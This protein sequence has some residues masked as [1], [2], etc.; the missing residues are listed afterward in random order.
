MIALLKSRLED[1]YD[2]VLVANT[3]AYIYKNLRRVLVDV[4]NLIPFQTVVSELRREVESSPSDEYDQASY[5]YALFIL[6]TYGRYEDVQQ[7][8][9]WIRSIDVKWM[10]YL[11]NHYERN[12]APIESITRT[13]SRSLILFTFSEATSMDAEQSRYS[14][15]NIIVEIVPAGLP[16]LIPKSVLS[17]I[18]R[19]T[20]H[21]PDVVEGKLS[22]FN[23]SEPIQ[24]DIPVKLEFNNKDV[25]ILRIFLNGIPVQTPGLLTFKYESDEVNGTIE[26][27]VTDPPVSTATA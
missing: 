9:G 10:H 12:I 14:I 24:E 1:V 19:R 18:V 7:Q 2:V 23:N 21:E 16:L 13:I 8:L 22:V 11:T 15:F 26:V 27:S 5:V 25:K 20:T 6:M 3:P 17:L 4:V